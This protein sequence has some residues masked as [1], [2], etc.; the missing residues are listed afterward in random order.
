MALTIELSTEEEARLNRD[1]T[2]RGLQASEYLR[3]LWLA[4]TLIERDAEGCP[5][6]A[7]TKTRVAQI[8]I[9][10]EVH[11]NTPQ[12]IVS[13]AYPHLSLDQVLAALAFYDSHKLEVLAGIEAEERLFIELRAKSGQTTREELLKRLHQKQA[14]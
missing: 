8:A 13:S 10:Q 7:G 4:E 2:K 12:Q 5:R 3:L 11:G 9:A 1:A 14:S 6:I